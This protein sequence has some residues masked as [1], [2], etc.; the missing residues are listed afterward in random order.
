MQKYLEMHRGGAA[1]T[2]KHVIDDLSTWLYRFKHG[3]Q[4]VAAISW[5]DHLTR[6]NSEN[7]TLE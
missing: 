2:L 5:R 6:C 4:K 3:D 1:I 7:S